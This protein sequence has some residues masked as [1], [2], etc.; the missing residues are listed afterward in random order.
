MATVADITETHNRKYAVED[1]YSILP[2]LTGKVD[3]VQGQPAVVHHSSAGMFALRLGDWKLIDG[4][5]SGGFTVPRFV[6]QQPGGP[7]VQLFNLRDDPGETKD[8]AG[9]HPDKVAE[10]KAMLERIRSAR[11]RVSD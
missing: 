11:V 4:L 3:R 5:G 2:V 1:S 7:A 9:E 8:L 10:L 6:K